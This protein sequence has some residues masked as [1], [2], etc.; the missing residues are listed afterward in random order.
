M[1]AASVPTYGPK[2]FTIVRRGGVLEL[3]ATRDFK[4]HEILLAPVTSVSKDCYWTLGARSA[5]AAIVSR[6]PRA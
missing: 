2:D 3:W 4:K 1:V 5:V 6:Q